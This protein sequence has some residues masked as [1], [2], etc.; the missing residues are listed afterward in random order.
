MCALAVAALILVGSV[1]LLRQV[2]V[3]FWPRK[4]PAA[5]SWRT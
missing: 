5:Q 1:A 2:I 3:R 4:G